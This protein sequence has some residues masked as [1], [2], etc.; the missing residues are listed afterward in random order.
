MTPILQLSQQQLIKV[1]SELSS[2]LEL[3][4]GRPTKLICQTPT[5]VDEQQSTPITHKNDKSY[6]KK[7]TCGVITRPDA[8]HLRKFNQ[9]NKI[10]PIE[11]D[12]RHYR[13]IK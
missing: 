13:A 10:H 4:S 6:S 3:A 8:E 1:I 12:L 2:I 7:K 11:C 9:N 5:H